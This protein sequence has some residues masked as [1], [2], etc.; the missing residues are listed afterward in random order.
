MQMELNATCL[1]HYLET[2]QHYLETLNDH[3]KFA[4]I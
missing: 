4:N 1:Q 3:P 2:I